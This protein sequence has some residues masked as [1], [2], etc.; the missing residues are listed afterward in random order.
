MVMLTGYMDETGHSKDGQQRFVGVAGLVAPAENWAAF[1]RKWDEALHV[2]KLSYFHMK[3]FA[4]RRKYFEGWSEPKR[5]K[6]L[7]KLLRIIATTHPFPVGAIVSLDDYR[8]FS[9]ADRALMG[10]PYHFC[11]M[12]CVYLP[13]WRT[14]RASPDVRVKIVFGEQTEFR[15]LA[16]LLLDDFKQNNASGKRFDPPAFADMKTVVQLQAADLVAYELYKEFER[17]RYRPQDRP[18][19]GYEELMKITLRSYTLMPFIFHTRDTLAGFVKYLK[20]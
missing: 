15:H 4:S 12:G 17:C 6:L 9:A 20:S 5:K 14:E 3:D 16:G 11:L 19:Y 13:A 10:D 7:G 8:S 2:F 1:E 18:R